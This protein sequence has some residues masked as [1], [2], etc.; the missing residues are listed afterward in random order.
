VT[1]SNDIYHIT[2]PRRVAR[3]F[4]SHVAQRWQKIAQLLPFIGYV[5]D[6]TDASNLHGA[7]VILYGGYQK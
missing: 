7:K 3:S 1:E 6:A 5:S 4:E 2:Q